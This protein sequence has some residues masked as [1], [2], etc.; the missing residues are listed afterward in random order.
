MTKKNGVASG[1]GAGHR[2]LDSKDPFCPGHFVYQYDS[3][4]VGGEEPAS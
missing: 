3:K 4:E 2:E 1:E